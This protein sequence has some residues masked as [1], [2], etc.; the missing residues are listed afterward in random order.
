METNEVL[1]L[2]LS[3]LDTVTTRLDGLEAGQQELKAG[4]QKL[5]QQYQ[6]L[7][8]RIAANAVDTSAMFHMQ[9]EYLTAE[10]KREITRI[11]IR[12]EHELIDKIKILHDGYQMLYNH[13]YS[14]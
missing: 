14:A 5:E 12:I 11:E 4:Q 6:A 9:N 7:D 3:K 13:I 10:F 1:Q 8:K 2:I